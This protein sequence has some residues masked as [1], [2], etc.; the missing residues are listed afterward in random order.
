MVPATAA[1]AVVVPD[2][3]EAYL[4]TGDWREILEAVEDLQDTDSQV[5]LF[6]GQHHPITK[7]PPRLVLTSQGSWEELA[8]ISPEDYDQIDT[9]HRLYRP[10][11]DRLP[12]SV[13]PAPSAGPSLSDLISDGLNPAK[14]LTTSDD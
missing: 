8:R 2:D 6:T 3:G 9:S 10:V 5:F 7:G 11:E 12:L 1:H 14:L 13:P 4:I